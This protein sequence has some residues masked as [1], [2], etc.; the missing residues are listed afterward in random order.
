MSYRDEPGQLTPRMRDVLRAAAR[1]ASSRE[2]ALELHVS[3]HTVQH[4]RAAASTRLEARNIT[5]AVAIA[6][7]R[8]EL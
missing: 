3:E 8:G 4:L 5:A 7:S 1:G 2:T 6:V